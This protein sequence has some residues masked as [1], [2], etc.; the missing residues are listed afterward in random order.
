VAYAVEAGKIRAN[1]D[2]EGMIQ[3]DPVEK[4]LRVALMR[5]LMQ[6]ELEGYADQIAACAAETI[7]KADVAPESI[8]RIVYVGGSSL[9]GVIQHRMEAL[10]PEARP[11][12]SEVFTA[13]VDGL[14]L[15]AGRDS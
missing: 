6:A 9:L 15:A 1:G 13:V 3:L 8:D 11:E 7:A 14:A 2:G 12:T 10:L 4:G 5:D